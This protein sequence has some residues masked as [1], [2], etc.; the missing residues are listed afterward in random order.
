MSIIKLYHGSENVIEKPQLG[1]GKK[2]NDY[3]QGFYCTEHIELAKEWA[4]ATEKSGYANEYELDM[5]DLSVLNLSLKEY[6]VLN[7]LAI[8][9]AN[10]IVS[11]Q[12]P[13]EKQGADYIIANFLPEYEKYDVIVGYRADDSYFSFA[14]AFCSNTITLA[15]LGYAMKLGE[16]GIQYVLKSPKAFSNLKFVSFCESD[17]ELYHSKRKHRDESARA[18]YW[19]Q[20]EVADTNGLFIRDIIR[21]GMKN[22]DPRIQ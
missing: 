22:N 16:L 12:T 14:R 10:R 21:E 8:L 3:G 17:G 1:L 7:W 5:T 18:A 11:Y 2:N 13:V 15:Q 19:K 4:C 6:N 20:L 9:L